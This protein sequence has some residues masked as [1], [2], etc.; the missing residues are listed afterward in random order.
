MPSSERRTLN[1]PKV[2][3]APPSDS[4]A[5]TVSNKSSKIKYYVFTYPKRTTGKRLLFTKHVWAHSRVFTN[6]LR[7]K[8]VTVKAHARGHKGRFLL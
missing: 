7:L 6:S 5:S 2:A 8:T 1:R 3:S 4:P